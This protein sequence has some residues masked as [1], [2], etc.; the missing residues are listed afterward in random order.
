MSAGEKKVALVLVVVLVALVGAYFVT[1]R[2]ASSAATGMPGQPMAP[3]ATATATAAPGG[4][5]CAPTPGAGAGG[6]AT[7]EFGK[8]G[9]KVEIVAALPITHGCH[10]KTEA[11]LKKAYEKYPSD[12]HLT[13]YDL[14]GPEGQAYVKEHGGQRAVVFINGNTTFELKGKNV[15]L[16]MTEGGSYVP[17]QIVPI[18]DQTVKGS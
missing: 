10:V 7:Q 2:S 17:D 12:I 9:A 6:V 18:V 14:F 11:E 16:E 3:G 8:A 4:P 5:T 1:G 13:I 15:K